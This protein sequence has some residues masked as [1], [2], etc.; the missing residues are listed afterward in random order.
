M[1]CP[2][3]LGTRFYE[4]NSRKKNLREIQSESRPAE[5]NVIFSD[6][7]LYRKMRCAGQ[8]RLLEIKA[9]SAEDSVAGIGAVGKIVLNFRMGV[10]AVGGKEA[11]DRVAKT[12]RCVH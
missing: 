11:I 6:V 2:S 1:I 7:K 4:G 3:L 12:E 9:E 8:Q 5:T 10:S